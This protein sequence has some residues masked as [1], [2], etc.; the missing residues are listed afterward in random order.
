VQVD[1]A[2]ASLGGSNCGWNIAQG[3][4]GYPNDPCAKTGLTPPVFG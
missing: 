2:A 3:S 1:V 4:L